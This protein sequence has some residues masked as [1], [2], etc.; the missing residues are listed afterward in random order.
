MISSGAERIVGKSLCPLP[1]TTAPDWVEETC[2]FSIL[3]ASLAEG[4]GS[5]GKKNLPAMRDSIPGSGR[6]LG[7]GPGNPL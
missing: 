4:I 7:G 6:S 2:P 3:L 5:D 1:P